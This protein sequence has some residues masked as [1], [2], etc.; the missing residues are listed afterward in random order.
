MNLWRYRLVGQSDYRARYKQRC[1]GRLTRPRVYFTRCIF[2]CNAC[3][4]IGEGIL[5]T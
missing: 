3:T 2:A 1:K 5:V 4:L